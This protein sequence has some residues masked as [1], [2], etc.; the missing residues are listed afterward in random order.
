MEL[1]KNKH[2]IEN[3]SR[4]FEKV[5]SPHRIISFMHLLKAT[6]SPLQGSFGGPP[7]CYKISLLKVDNNQD[8]LLLS[9]FEDEEAHSLLLK[10]KVL[11]I[12]SIVNGTEYSFQIPLIKIDSQGKNIQY[13]MSLP[14]T[15]FYSQR[16]E[17]RRVHLSLALAITASFGKDSGQTIVG[18]LR[19][20]S[21][22]G[23][24]VQFSKTSPDEFAVARSVAPC[25]ITF[26]DNSDI[27]CDFEIR[28]MRPHKHDKG[29]TIGASFHDL[30]ITKKSVINK[31]MTA[32]ERKSLRGYGS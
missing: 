7:G 27:Q 20:I 10:Y 32:I 4:N 30:D 15:V 18:Q 31:F 29:C 28:Y 17:S 19:D 24:R 21:S 6:G 5:T 1:Q 9:Q 8:Y 2:K 16:R 13:K 22:G 14:K 3:Q 11:R 26:P 12:F 25:T 23:M